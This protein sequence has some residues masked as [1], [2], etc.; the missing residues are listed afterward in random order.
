MDTKKATDLP[1]V[2]F[3]IDTDEKDTP[4]MVEEETREL[5]NNPRGTAV[6]GEVG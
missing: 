1:G 5:N 6:D 4:K 2:D 3:N